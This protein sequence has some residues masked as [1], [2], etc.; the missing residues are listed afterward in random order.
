MDFQEP[1]LTTKIRQRHEQ[2]S[3]C[4][5]IY[6]HADIA[7][8]YLWAVLSSQWLMN[9]TQTCILSRLYQWCDVTTV[10]IWNILKT[11]PACPICSNTWNTCTNVWFECNTKHWSYT[12]YC[13][14]T[15]KTIFLRL[16]SYCRTNNPWWDTVASP[17]SF[18]GHACMSQRYSQKC[19]VE[20]NTSVLC[21]VPYVFV[22]FIVELHS[23]LVKTQP[24]DPG[25]CYVLFPA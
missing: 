18:E 14:P 24:Y 7:C 12:K 25:S 22:Y 21:G 16:N 3:V 1:K 15:N 19:G 2:I 10:D 17:C 9:I 8:S 20:H 23:G 11:Q 13:G 4:D 6:V 5:C